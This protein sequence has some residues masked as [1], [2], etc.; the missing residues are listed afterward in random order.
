M[1]ETD[2]NRKNLLSYVQSF[3][4]K[5]KTYLTHPDVQFFICYELKK[6]RRTERSESKPKHNATNNN[7]K[8]ISK[9]LYETLEDSGARY[10]QII[11]NVTPAIVKIASLDQIFTDESIQI[12]MDE[13]F[14]EIYANCTNNTKQ[15][16]YRNG[17]FPGII[18]TRFD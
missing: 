4:K 13:W 1:I 15:F 6:S 8:Q 7:K 16:F 9:P 3:Y 18:Q 17:E 5:L 14:P 11:K 2:I 12:I 10:W